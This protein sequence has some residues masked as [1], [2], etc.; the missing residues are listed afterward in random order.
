MRFFP[1]VER[2]LRVMSRGRRVYWGRFLA[3]LIALALVTWVWFTLTGGSSVD[4]GKQIFTALSFLV[5]VY[6]L[7]VGVFLTADWA[8]GCQFLPR[9]ALATA[10]G[11]WNLALLVPQ[12]IAPAIA[13][14]VLS[15]MHA[16]NSPNAASIAFVTASIEVAIGIAW[17]WRLP[18]SRVSCDTWTNG[19]NP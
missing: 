17:I 7:I 18:G 4:L 9:F 15:A 16:L 11:I 13:T 10:M 2:E 6:C 1:V 12:I 19:N 3:A 8:L 5:F 14:A